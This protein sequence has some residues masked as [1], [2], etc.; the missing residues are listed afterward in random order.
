FV[1]VRGFERETGAPRPL[2]QHLHV[3]ASKVPRRRN[4][5]AAAAEQNSD[6]AKASAHGT[7]SS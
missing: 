1:C 5:A 4:T 2:C 3:A 7:G 6:P